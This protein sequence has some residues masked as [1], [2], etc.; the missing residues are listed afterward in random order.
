MNEFGMGQGKV[1]VI[2]FG[3]A[4]AEPDMLRTMTPSFCRA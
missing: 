1:P 4:I 3:I 2:S